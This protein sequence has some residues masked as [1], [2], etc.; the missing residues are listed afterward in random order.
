MM[1]KSV[2][3]SLCR[4]PCREFRRVHR[5]TLSLII[6]AVWLNGRVISRQSLRQD[7]DLS[8]LY[9]TWL[10][11]FYLEKFVMRPKKRTL[12]RAVAYCY[13]AIYDPDDR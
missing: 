4:E 1:I 8:Q 2:L 9:T 6:T 7:S 11:G 13:T 5:R 10:E 12:R 3:L